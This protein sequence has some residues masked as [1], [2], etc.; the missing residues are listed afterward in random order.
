MG[1]KMLELKCLITKNLIF[2]KSNALTSFLEIFI[3]ILLMTLIVLIRVSVPKNK[4]PQENLLAQIDNSRQ[5]FM[6]STEGLENLPFKN[7]FSQ[8]AKLTYAVV[9]KDISFINYLTLN[10]KK[11]GLENPEGHFETLSE[12]ENYIQT[13]DYIENPK[14]CFAVILEQPQKKNLS[15]ISNIILQILFQKSL[16]D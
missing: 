4:F 11:Y 15:Y 2:W 6:Q 12:I 9:S 1:R 13:S 14:L 3:P 16:L 10:L 5:V 8:D 7:C